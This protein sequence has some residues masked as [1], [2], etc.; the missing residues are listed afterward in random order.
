MIE[1]ASPALA[2]TGERGAPDSMIMSKRD[3]AAP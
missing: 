2:M 3:V 1:I